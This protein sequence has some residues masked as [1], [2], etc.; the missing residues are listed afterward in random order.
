MLIGLRYGGSCDWCS[1]L[2]VVLVEEGL[3]PP[4]KLHGLGRSLELGGGARI[5]ALEG[6]SL[7][8]L[9]ISGVASEEEEA[10]AEAGMEGTVVAEAVAVETAVAVAVA[11]I[12]GILGPRGLYLSPSLASHGLALGIHDTHVM[13]WLDLASVHQDCNWCSLRPLLFVG[14]LL[15]SSRQFRCQLGVV[16]PLPP[17][18]FHEGCRP[19]RPWL[20]WW[21]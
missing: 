15:G 1:Q 4:I 6:P 3:Q 13:A 21:L 12:G 2:G 8:V 10:V 17:I 16:T 11:R 18:Q 9:P 20:W 5:A 14:S 7:A 19:L